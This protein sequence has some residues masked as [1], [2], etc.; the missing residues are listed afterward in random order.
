MCPPHLCTDRVSHLSTVDDLGV[1]D[2]PAD[3]TGRSRL[4]VPS[5]V[6]CSHSVTSKV[7]VSGPDGG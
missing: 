4:S 7:G 2:V 1:P 6:L 5:L 3:K